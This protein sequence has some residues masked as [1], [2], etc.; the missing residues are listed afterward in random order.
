MDPGTF[1]DPTTGSLW[2]TYG[3]YF[4]YIRV[5][6]LNPKTGM[7]LYP[8]LKPFDVAINRGASTM[9]YHDGWYYLLA[10][11]GSGCRGAD[12]GYN[13]RV[14]RGRKPTGPFVDDNGIDMILGGGN[15]L[16][17][18]GG[19]LVGPGHFGLI[20]VGDGIQKFSMPWEADFDR[21][22]AS[23]IDIRPLL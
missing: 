22:G 7:R 14:D 2:L 6:E 16:I 20:D 15:L 17:G 18:S 13:I 8:N 3:S 19:R 10:T 23:V 12:S 11:H 4:G 9:I 5:V 1:L 21:G